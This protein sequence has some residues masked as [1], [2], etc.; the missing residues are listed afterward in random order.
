MKLLNSTTA[1]YFESREQ[2]SNSLSVTLILIVI[3]MALVA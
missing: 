2:E 1:L 3:G